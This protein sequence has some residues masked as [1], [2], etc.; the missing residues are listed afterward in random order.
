[1]RSAAAALIVIAGNAVAHPGHGAPGEHF[2]AWGI[3]HALL[4]LAFLFFLVIA[5][6]R[7]D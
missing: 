5:L 7:K 4:L 2:H 1:M 6:R 3:E